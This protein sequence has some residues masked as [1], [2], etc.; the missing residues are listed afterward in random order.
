MTQALLNNLNIIQDSSFSVNDNSVK[1]AVHDFAKIFDSKTSKNTKTN[2]NSNDTKTESVKKTILDEHN[3][4][5]N[6]KQTLGDLKKDLKTDDTLKTEIKNA[7]LES[8]ADTVVDLTIIKEEIE[9]AE[10]IVNAAIVA[11][12]SADNDDEAEI[13]TETENQAE[14]EIIDELNPITEEILETIIT[15]ED[16][17]MYKELDTLENPTVAIML[18]SQIQTTVKKSASENSTEAKLVENNSRTKTGENSL[19]NTNVFKQFDN[20]PSTEAVA[21]APKEDLN[22]KT[23]APKLSKVL[24]DKIVKDLNVRVVASENEAEAGTND[25]MQKQ[26]PQEQAVKVMIQGDVKFDK[27]QFD[28]VKLTE[29]K[30]TEVST[31]KII[32]QISKQLDGMYNNTKLNMV[33]NPGTLGKVNLHIVNSKDGLIAQ[34]MV[35]TQE[36]KDILMKGLNGLKESLLSQGINVDNVSVKLEETKESENNSD[37]TEQ[38]GSGGGNKQQGSQRQQKNEEKP[39]EQMMLELDKDGKV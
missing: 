5:E 34:F 2:D 3:T 23:E 36:A 22:I 1:A 30:P 39:F 12:N 38:E 32:E 7:I 8:A 33:L 29:V 4:K 14:D 18:H 37:W 21:N 28:A 10:E 27:L 11:E 13:T 24:D 25:L 17:T 19:N 6:N 9:E 26:T 35:T 16:P 20:M 31:N 15:E